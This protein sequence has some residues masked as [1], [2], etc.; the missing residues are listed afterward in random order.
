M[1]LFC[2]NVLT[3]AKLAA[4]QAD[5]SEGAGG[6]AAVR[7]EMTLRRGRFSE[8]I[9]ILPVALL[10][11][12]GA[13]SETAARAQE[14]YS[15]SE[16]ASA[17]LLGTADRTPTDGVVAETNTGPVRLARFSFL[18]GAVSWREDADS[19]WTPATINMPLREG[20]VIKVNGSSRAE[21]QFDDGS[22]LRLG[23]GAVVTLQTLYSDDNGEFTELRLDQGLMTLRLKNENSVYQVNT[24][25]IAAKAA[26]PAKI[27]FGRGGD[28]EIAVRQG[29]VSI[30]GAPGKA[31]LTAGDYL[32]FRD[33]DDRF[34][35]ADLPPIDRWD[36][37]NEQRDRVMDNPARYAENCP[38]SVALVAGD[39]DDYGSWRDDAQYGKVWCPTVVEAEWRPYHHG[40]WVWMQSFGWTWVSSEPWGWAPYHYGTWVH[41]AYGWAWV[42]GPAVQPWCPAVVH[43]TSYGGNVA[44]V[45]LAPCEV[46]Y[47]S[48]IAVRYRH[49]NW[50]QH[51]SIGTTCIY[52]PASHTT[53]APRPCH[54][55]YSHAG[56][57]PHDFHGRP[58]PPH[59]R[60]PYSGQLASERFHVVP[61]NARFSGVSEV[62]EAGFTGHTPFRRIPG[63]NGSQAFEHG[64]GGV[65][66]IGLPPRPSTAASHGRPSVGDANA[67]HPVHT[68]PVAGGVRG[69]TGHEDHPFSSDSPRHDRPS[70]SAFGMTPVPV[71]RP[72]FP[73][74]PSAPPTTTS[75]APGTTN[76][77]APFERRYPR[78]D[79]TPDFHRRD[80]D[81]P[82]R[83]EDI[84]VGSN[85]AVNGPTPSNP[86]TLN[87]PFDPGRPRIEIPVR[88]GSRGDFVD[89]QEDAAARRQPFRNAYPTAP[90]N[91]PRDMPRV[92]RPGGS[93][94]QRRGSDFRSPEQ[95]GDRTDRPMHIDRVE[96]TDRT[97]R[98]DRSDSPAPA[99]RRDNGSNGSQDTSRNSSRG[100]SD[101]SR[102]F[103][104]RHRSK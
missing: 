103:G 12:L 7:K 45:P 81:L 96:R 23:R 71:R 22:L 20:A 35:I 101:S 50:A 87:R 72:S 6:G 64:H 49:G 24:G 42:P 52:Q 78:Q 55:Y 41:A 43:F 34:Q 63:S 104:G 8:N 98:S 58:L 95:G 47:P 46:R 56:P 3:G 57:V 5:C 65:T 77:P 51:F 79:R 83:R 4:S 13:L 102:D 33:E 26:G 44:W 11:T 73:Q 18:Q 9:G 70:F 21:V 84:S 53:F 2:V 74:T 97:D 30:N 1:N 75:S 94:E 19:P 68:Y 69:N 32:D 100:R 27:R 59:G 99:Q 86:T 82:G 88:S 67:N 17:S 61:F 48:V 10:L 40:R 54:E 66:M 93:F 25:S 62:N 28:T 39:L 16:A 37:F 29:D 14:G 85:G 36:Q 60:T 80:G 15:V 89:R 31:S 38:S 90:D 92:E 91:G 76:A